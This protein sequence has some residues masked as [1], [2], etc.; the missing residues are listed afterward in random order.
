VITFGRAID[1]AN[2]LGDMMLKQFGVG[3]LLSVGFMTV[4]GAALAHN[5]SIEPQAE[6]SIPFFAPTSADFSWAHPDVLPNV[7]D[8]QAI[9]SYLSYGDVDWYQFVVTPADLA[10]GPVLV[11]ASALP[12]GCLEYQNVYPVTALLGPQA[13]SPFGPPGLPA[14]VAGQSFPFTVPAG[15][16]V[17]MAN[18]PR[19]PY[20][21]KREI[22]ALEEGD[23]GDISWFLPKGLSQ[24]CLL[25]AQWLCDFSNTI[26]QPVF[27]PGTYYI[28]MWNPTGIPTDYTA[29]IGYSEANFTPNPEAEAEIR[30][31]GLLHRSCHDPYPFR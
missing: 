23:L 21:Q 11:A 29:N 30:D 27:Y 10:F 7:T 13:P 28:A 8:S 12:P 5:T 26:A 18:N 14:P 6:Y 24:N 31:N 4:S 3:A 17:V 9:F 19:I 1:R 15:M 2:K 25:N 22:F 20:P 16:G